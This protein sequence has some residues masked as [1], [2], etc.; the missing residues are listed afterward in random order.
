MAASTR[1]KRISIVVP[2]YNAIKF[3]SKSVESALNQTH[4]NLELILVND[5][6]TDSSEALCREYAKKDDRVKVFAQENKGPAAARNHGVS[7]ATGD[8]IF[9]L[10]ADDFIE[11]DSLKILLDGYEDETT[12]LVMGNFSKLEN[13]GRIVQQNVTFKAGNKPFDGD[14][15]QLNPNTAGDYVRHFLR[16]PSNHLISY[17]WARLYKKS[18]IDEHGLKADESMQLF[19][20][21]IFNLQYMSVSKSIVFVNK[22][23]YMYVMHNSH[24]SASMTMLD[25]DS[26]LHDMALFDEKVLEY[27]KKL[28]MP[29]LPLS[30]VVKEIGHA[31][32]HYTIIFIVRTCRNITAENRRVIYDQIRKL[33]HDPLMIRSLKCYTPAK[34]NSRAVP[35][36]MKMKMVRPL[37][38]LSHYKAIKRYGKFCEAN[39]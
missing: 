32:V 25:S 36:L 33:I 16:H 22:S 37:M 15:K 24:V 38:A 6:S 1:D 31:L 8:Y 23:V 27:Y 29:D 13:D 20:D 35:F 10:D 28:N 4:S 39:S 19:E 34:G 9:F 12:D 11:S 26:L 21:L 3:L 2:V 7:K 18:I 5:G 30:Q 17:C 14:V